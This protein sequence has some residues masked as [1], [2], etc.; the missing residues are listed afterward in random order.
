M[1]VSSPELGVPPEVI[2]MSGSIPSAAPAAAIAAPS[3]AMGWGDHGAGVLVSGASAGWGEG[4]VRL[5]EAAAPGTIV[6][7]R[8]KLSDEDGGKVHEVGVVGPATDLDGAETSQVG[9]YLFQNS[10]MHYIDGEMQRLSGEELFSEG[11]TVELELDRIA[12]TLT[13]RNVTDEDSEGAVETVGGLPPEGLLYPAACILNGE[14]VRPSP[15]ISP[16]LPI[17]PSF[18]SLAMVGADRQR[19]PSTLA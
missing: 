12:H 1:S 19:E 15:H 8:V 16:H 4:Y 18:R 11:S 13:V 2:A 9:V 7:W 6:K 10:P 14:Q 5:R 17:R 3:I